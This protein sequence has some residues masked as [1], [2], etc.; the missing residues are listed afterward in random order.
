MCDALVFEDSESRLLG[1]TYEY[2]K[3]KQRNAR[4]GN[5]TLGIKFV[6]QNMPCTHYRA[7]TN[8]PSHHRPEANPSR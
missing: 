1:A 8:L 5:G 6:S 3:A 2:A 7:I 4:L